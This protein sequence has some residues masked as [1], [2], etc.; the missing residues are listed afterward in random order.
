MSEEKKKKV[1]TPDI[2][3]LHA[4]RYCAYQERCQQE[5]RDKLYSF[6][7][8]TDAIEKIISELIEQ[9]FINEERFAKAYA[10]GKFRIKHWG[11]R[12]IELSLKKRGISSFCINKGL[13]EINEQEYIETLKDII[14]KQT[15]KSKETNPLKRNYKVAQ[16]CISRGFEGD[17][18]WDILK[19]E[20][21]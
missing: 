18:V 10:G 16:Y 19:L 13:Q 1:I 2:A 3:L 7:L 9:G 6:G 5:V 11:K 17:I 8:W 20:G 15:K 12:K 14:S 4:M 21:N